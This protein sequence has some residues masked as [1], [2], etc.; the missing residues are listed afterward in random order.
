MR[1]PD[2]GAA[3]AAPGQ[4]HPAGTLR[5]E[6]G[7][8]VACD[9]LAEPH[10]APLDLRV[11]LGEHP[12]ELC[13]VGERI[14]CARLVLG[15][16]QVASW[17]LATSPGQRPSTLED[18]EVFG[19]PVDSGVGCFMDARAA[20]V[21][22]DDDDAA[23]ALLEALEGEDALEAELPGTTANLVAF[24]SGQ[25][26][27]LF[28]TYV[29]YASDGETPLQLVTDF[30]VLPPAVPLVVRDRGRPAPDLSSAT[31]R[32]VL[33]A[34][35]APYVAEILPEDSGYNL[36]VWMHHHWTQNDEAGRQRVIWEVFDA[37]SVSGRGE[38]APLL[39]AASA[40]LE[41]RGVT[42]PEPDP[43]REQA[44]EGEW[45]FGPEP[46]LRAGSVPDYA[47]HF[48]DTSR[49]LDYPLAYSDRAYYLMLAGRLDEAE[50]ALETALAGIPE[51]PFPWSNRGDLHARRGELALA[52]E[53]WEQA[54]ARWNVEWPEEL[55]RLHAKL[56]RGR[57]LASGAAPVKE[58]AAKAVKKAAKQ[59]PG[60]KK[61]VATKKAAKKESAAKKPAAKKEPAA[62]KPAAKKP[63]AKKEPAAKKPAAK[64]PAAK[65]PAAKK[66][67]AAKKPA[68][69]K[70]AA[71]KPA[72]K[73][74]AAK[75]P[76]AKKRPA[77]KKPAA[78]KPAAKKPVAKKTAKKRPATKKAPA[79]KKQPLAKKKKR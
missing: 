61:K 54:L 40:A 41:T 18:G 16:G 79:A 51:H 19:Y 4:R 66:E 52:L 60:A 21:L 78:K 62:K 75:K 67:P 20:E 73:K 57:E 58:K 31:P 22:A 29:G 17:E 13:L 12:V 1:L 53:C 35:A 68:A 56:G 6:S 50:A 64:K 46:W 30:W 38:W 39:Q 59:E 45:D 5:V 43:E 63:A 47:Q 3:F 55:A 69:K 8:L 14:A 25:G 9:P 27:G 15:S 77:A 36:G 76:V 42:R 74:P 28:P 2:Y 33:Q 26:D 11:P 72:A 24:R 44:V 10:R 65:K 70:P 37:L 48:L 7:A 71:K 32:A 23:D 34:L 49:P